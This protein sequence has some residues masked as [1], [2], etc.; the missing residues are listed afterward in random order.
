MADSCAADES[1]WDIFQRVDQLYADWNMKRVYY[2][3]FRPVRHTPLEE[4]PETPMSREHR[5]YQMDWLKR[6]YR[7]S[8][9][10]L[11][12]AFD[13]GGFLP[14]D[15]DPKTTIAVANLDAFPLD[16]NAATKE[17][18]LRIPGVGPT[19][20]QRILETRRR[21]TID[22]WR[23]LEAMGVV[24]KRAWPFGLSWPAASNGQAVEA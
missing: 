10:E 21:H 22:T 1:D 8:N 6:V 7:F 23:D 24:R 19:S 18:L 5:L 13:R 14:T 3:A 11:K 12:L 9:E 15:T 17:Q 4:H 2:A 16:I 20:S